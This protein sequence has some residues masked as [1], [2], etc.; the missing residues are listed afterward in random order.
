[1]RRVLAPACLLAAAAVH[2]L[3]LTPAQIA[4]KTGPAVV[5]I[6]ADT[7]AG[8]SVG[9]GFIVDPLGTVVT[10]LHVVE[11]ATAIRVK[12]ASGLAYDHVR[13]RAFD[14]R[15]DLAILQL[16]G[17]GLPSV[18]LG[19]SGSLRPGAPV[20]VLGNPRG[21]E[22]GISLGR[23]RRMRMLDTGLKVIETDANADRG[24]SGAPLVTT[25]GR[26]VGVLSFKVKGRRR[27]RFAIPIE[28]ARRLISSEA[29]PPE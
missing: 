16:A 24:S 6:T 8:E 28:Y 21:R 7:A 27:T 4:Q 22:G 26:V 1:V 5:F 10:S 20:V 15:A 25:D 2:A 11:G 18:A 13:V 17:F 14:D 19:D 23:V 29:A 9:S 12:L 3:G